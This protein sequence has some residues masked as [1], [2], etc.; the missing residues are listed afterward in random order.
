MEEA[1][2]ARMQAEEYNYRHFGTEHVV[3]EIEGMVRRRAVP[4]GSLAP[5]FELPST[6]GTTVRLEELLT[7]PVLL[8]FGSLS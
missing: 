5:E 3:D 2:S 6:S 8:H 7:Q 1:K 4:P